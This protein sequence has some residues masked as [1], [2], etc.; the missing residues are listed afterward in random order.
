MELNISWSFWIEAQIGSRIVGVR[1]WT[2]ASP[3][4]TLSTLFLSQLYKQDYEK[5][6]KG[7]IQCRHIEKRIEKVQCSQIHIFA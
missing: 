1:G 7:S 6:E 3:N 5:K 4:K 2:P